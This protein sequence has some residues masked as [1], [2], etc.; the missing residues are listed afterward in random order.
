MAVSTTEG[1]VVVFGGMSATDT[2]GSVAVIR[3]EE[4]PRPA[5]FAALIAVLILAYFLFIFCKV[6]GVLGEGANSR[7]T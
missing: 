2:L 6:N 4:Q 7:L 3:V 1:Q 5:V